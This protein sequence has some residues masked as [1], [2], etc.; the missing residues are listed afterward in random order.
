MS[1]FTSQVIEAIRAIKDHETLAINLKRNQ[2]FDILDENKLGCVEK[3]RI[4]DLACHPSNRGGQMLNAHDVHVKGAAMV[5][6]GCDLTK[7]VEACCIEFSNDP[8]KKAEQLNS[9]VMLIKHSGGMLAELEGRE[10]KMTLAT[11]HMVAFCR[12]LVAGC[13]TTQV[14]LTSDGEH[15]SLSHILAGTSNVEQHPLHVMCYEGIVMRV[16]PAELEELFPDVCVM[17]QQSYNSSHTITKPPN[18]METAATIAFYYETLLKMGQK[19][20]LEQAVKNAGASMPQCLSYLPVLVHW[21]ANYAGGDSFPMVHFLE[22]YSSMFGESLI[23]GEVFLTAVSFA[24]FKFLERSTTAPFLRAACIATQ[25]TANRSEDGVAKLLVRTDIDRL[26]GQKMGAKVSEAEAVMAAA[27]QVLQNAQDKG[28]DQVIGAGIFGKFCTRCVLHL[29]D[30]ARFGREPKGH[31]SLDE[32]S[33]LFA[34]EISS[35]F[36]LGETPVQVSQ[37]RPSA[38][39]TLQEVKSLDE[40]C[41]P[42]KMALSKIKLNIGDFCN[43]REHG[44]KIFV[45]ASITATHGIFTHSPLFKQLNHDLADETATVDLAQLRDWKLFKGA[46]PALVEHAMLEKLLPNNN[47]FIKEESLK[48]WIYQQL[49]DNYALQGIEQDGLVFATSPDMIFT[50]QRYKKGALKLHPVGTVSRIKQVDGAP[51]DAK[52][53]KHLVITIK[54][55]KEPDQL[56]MVSSPKNSVAISPYHWLRAISTEADATMEIHAMCI[57]DEHRSMHLCQKHHHD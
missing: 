49:V 15:L 27:W 57:K 52:I 53:P 12:A 3:V 31:A 41:D 9:N 46:V 39:P 33:S 43:H 22:K 1:A 5:T 37:E 10:R 16:L 14:Q 38:E 35:K 28:L 24:E 13:K 6:T 21:V 40:C 47:E 55:K 7:L 20:T 25:L 19:P 30:K 34:N 48:A 42:A 11:S 23:L 54:H 29:L 2:I 18:E 56:F 50:G 51:A 17:I 32:I 8:K 45:F 26:K 44:T 4:A 36:S